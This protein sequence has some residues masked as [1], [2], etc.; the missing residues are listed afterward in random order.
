M[1]KS[2]K[3]K[4]FLEIFGDFSYKQGFCSGKQ[5]LLMMMMMIMMM[6]MMMMMMIM[7]MIMM[8]MVMMLLSM[9]I[10]K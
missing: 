1:Q 5:D 9:F 7:I 4:I 8:I 2:F 6:I 3:T 10:H